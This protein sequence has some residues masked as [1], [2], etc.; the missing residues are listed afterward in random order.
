MKTNYIKR[1]IEKTVKHY[2]GIF[3]AVA[4]LG[5]R[6]TGKTTMLQNIFEKNYKYVSLDDLEQREYAEN[7]PKGFLEDLGSRV[8]IDEI[9]YV[10]KLFSYVK[11]KIDAEPSVMGRYIFTGSQ[12]FLIM[13]DFTE[14]LA[15]RI[16]I[17]NMHPLACTEIPLVSA[18]PQVLFEQ[19]SIRGGYPVLWKKRNLTPDEWYKSYIKIYI[20]RDVRNL[21]N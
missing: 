16:G 7:D 20:E 19:G 15:G 18:K 17:I 11:M 1:D 5:A 21:F 6:Q 4:V 10:P 8:I 13:K 3:P 12:N 14:T 2:A 9:Q